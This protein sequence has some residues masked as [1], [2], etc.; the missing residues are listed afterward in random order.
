MLELCRTQFTMVMDKLAD[1]IR[2]ECQWTISFVAD[3]M[4]WRKANGGIFAEAE[5]CL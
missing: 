5:V 3:T 4:I 1:E 2:G